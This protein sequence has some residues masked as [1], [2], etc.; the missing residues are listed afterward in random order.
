M[1]HYAGKAAKLVLF[2]GLMTLLLAATANAAEIGSGVGAIT[3]SSVR[4]RSDASTSSDILK[5]MD[6]GSAVSILETLD[7]WFRIAYDGATG[8]VS[9]DY[10]TVDQD[11]AFTAAGRVNSDGVNVRTGPGTDCDTAAS[12]DS[13]TLVTVNGFAGGW[14]SVTCQYGTTGYIRSDFL[15]LTA[16]SASASGQS[17]QIVSSARQYLGTRYVYGGSSPNGF[18]CSGFTM[19]IYQQYGYSL[20]HTAT[21]QWQSSTGAKVWSVSSLQTGDLVFFC[22]PSRS[23]GKACSHAGIYIGDGQFIHASSSRSGGVI[24]SSLY[25][26]Y[27]SRYFVGGKHVG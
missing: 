16:D 18:D 13:G 3:G 11:N 21:G 10:L 19:Y 6:K 24:I 2:T 1:T 15:D 22:D 25:E 12:V 27:Y 26:D 5:T 23:L 17:Q 7:G 9:S 4:M 14:Y 8:Y 20:P